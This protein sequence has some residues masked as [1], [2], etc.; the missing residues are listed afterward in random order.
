MRSVGA[1]L[2]KSTSKTTH[3]RRL[4]ST[5]TTLVTV[6]GANAAPRVG[7]RGGRPGNFV[8]RRDRHGLAVHAQLEIFALQ[9]GNRLALLIEHARRN[10]DHFAGAAKDRLVLRP[11]VRNR[12]DGQRE[13]NGLHP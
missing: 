6:L 9:P 5:G 2:M 13:Q 11:S 1:V 10:Q 8:E 7:G 3:E 12:K 4:L